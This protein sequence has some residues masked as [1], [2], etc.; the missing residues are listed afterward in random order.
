MGH[1]GAIT[2]V[3][4]MVFSTTKTTMTLPSVLPQSTLGPW[5]FV[6]TALSDAKANIETQPRR[7]GVPSANAD[8]VSAAITIAGVNRRYARVWSS[9]C[10]P[11]RRDSAPQHSRKKEITKAHTQ[12]RAFV[13]GADSG[14]ISIDL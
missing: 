7:H 14:S 2:Y 11:T 13:L 6:I 4:D 10:L 5:F 9:T 8:V 3:N 12:E 1:P